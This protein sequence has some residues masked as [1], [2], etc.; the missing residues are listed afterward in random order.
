VKRED[1]AKLYD[2][3]SN[4]PKGEWRTEYPAVSIPVGP[5]FDGIARRGHA[6]Q[7]HIPGRTLPATVGHQDVRS[8][9]Y[10]TENIGSGLV[11]Q[12]LVERFDDQPVEDPVAEFLALCGRNVL[13]IADAVNHYR[14]LIDQFKQEDEGE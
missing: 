10:S 11:R 3:V 4:L 14:R 7:V 6:N 13:F 8:G 9:C 5:G 2:Y 1:V 12:K